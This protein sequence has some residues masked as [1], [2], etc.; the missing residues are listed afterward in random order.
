[1]GEYP[2]SS[3][4][5]I[6]NSVWTV[7]S[8]PTNIGKIPASALQRGSVVPSADAILSWATGV[9]ND[10]RWLAIFWHVSLATFLIAV[11]RSRVSERFVVLLLVLPVVSVAVLAW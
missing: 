4:D 2:L 7:D 9:A 6:R 3:R 5:A 11:S 1:M 10:W 8:E